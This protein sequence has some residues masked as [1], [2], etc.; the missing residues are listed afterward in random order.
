MQLHKCRSV[1]VD[2]KLLSNFL[3]ALLNTTSV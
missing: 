3:R 1:I 2:Y